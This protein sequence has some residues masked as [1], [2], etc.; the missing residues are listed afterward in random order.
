MTIIKI[1]IHVFPVKITLYWRK[2]I[3]MEKMGSILYRKIKKIYHKPKQYNT[4][5]EH[6]G[7]TYVRHLLYSYGNTIPN[8]HTHTQDH[9]WFSIQYKTYQK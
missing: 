2:K 1:T 6:F 9:F 5:I 7:D 8:M 3:N 4:C